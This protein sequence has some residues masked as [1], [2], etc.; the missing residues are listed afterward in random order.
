MQKEITGI[1]RAL[2]VSC[3]GVV[4]VA[5]QQVWYLSISEDT[6]RQAVFCFS[7]RD[8]CRGDGV[9]FSDI[10][11]YEVNGQGE[12]ARTVWA[13]EPNPDIENNTVIKKI[14]FGVVP[15]NW[16]ESHPYKGFEAGKFYSVNGKYYFRKREGGG[17]DV[18]EGSEFY[19]KH[20]W[21]K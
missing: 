8:N 16:T 9:H 11:F 6:S 18:L 7:Q 19:K 5:C 10:T 15:K 17:Y 4:S 12:A 2:L 3:L 21:K 13:V 20:V 14:I 1:G